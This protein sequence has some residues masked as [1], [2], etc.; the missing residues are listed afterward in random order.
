MNSK[1]IL[2]CSVCNSSIGYFFYCYKK[3]FIS[4][5][6]WNGV[7]NE[8]FPGF[9]WLLCILRNQEL[10]RGVYTI[11]FYYSI[12]YQKNL[13]FVQTDTV[14][15]APP[16]TGLVW[17]EN[18]DYF[19]KSGRLIFWII[20]SR[21]IVKFIYIV[22]FFFLLKFFYINKIISFQLSDNYRIWQQGF[23][24]YRQDNTV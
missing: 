16:V 22:V 10:H 21:Q 14:A 6:F 12:L 23:L 9:N 24:Q 18:L 19:C 2:F 5:S 8:Y 1:S 4:D 11:V 7:Q 3:N 17:C 13:V 15:S 20:I